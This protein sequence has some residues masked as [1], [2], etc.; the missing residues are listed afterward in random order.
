MSLNISHV[1][2]SPGYVPANPTI[3]LKPIQSQIVSCSNK[4]ILPENDLKLTG[5][6]MALFIPGLI[7]I[8]ECAH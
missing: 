7:S 1:G 4:T 8:K 2:G 6:P 5:V 3:I